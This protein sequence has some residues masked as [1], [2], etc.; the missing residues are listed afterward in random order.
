[1][2]VVG[3]RVCVMFFLPL[4]RIG[5]FASIDQQRKNES[6]QDTMYEMKM[7]ATGAHTLRPFV[8]KLG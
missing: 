6:K 1:M 8:Q 3:L 7:V 2:M 5:S 4:Q